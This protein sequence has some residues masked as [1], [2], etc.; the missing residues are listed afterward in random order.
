MN[1]NELVAMAAAMLDKAYVPYS[2]FPVG[3]AILCEDG[4][5]Y[6]GCNIENAAYGP[7]ICAE[8]AALC[9][10]ICEGNHKIAKV[11]V[12]GETEDYCY[13]CGV[14]RQTLYEFNPN[15]KIICGRRDGNI[16]EH[17]LHELLPNAFGPLTLNDK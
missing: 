8:R 5:V 13:P 11:A 6:S 15:M 14:C 9:R 3:A 12:V 4:S 7:T 16:V 10:A 1:N 2:K 17:Y